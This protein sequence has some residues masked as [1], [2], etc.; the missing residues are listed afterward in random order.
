MKKT[1]SNTILKSTKK[2][3]S[4]HGYGLKSIREI[5][6]RYQGN[7]EIKTDSGAFC[8]FLYLPLM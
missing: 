2:D 3:V 4:V 1:G 7:M 8:L 5:V 6:L